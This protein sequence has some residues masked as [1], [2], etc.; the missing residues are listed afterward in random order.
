MNGLLA[1]NKYI[2]IYVLRN[3]EQCLILFH[4]KYVII[5][6]MMHSAAGSMT[7]KNW[8]FSPITAVTDSLSILPG[9][10]VLQRA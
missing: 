6:L 4:N 2:S 10:S 8:I 9:I 7:L 3:S 5:T 1:E